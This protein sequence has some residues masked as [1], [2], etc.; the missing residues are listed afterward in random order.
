MQQIWH[1]CKSWKLFNKLSQE[2]VVGKVNGAALEMAE[3]ANPGSP[4]W[5]DSMLHGSKLGKFLT[6]YVDFLFIFFFLQFVKS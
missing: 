5:Q 3:F 6:S 1:I 2:E 4:S